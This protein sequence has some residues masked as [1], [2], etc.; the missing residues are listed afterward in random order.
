MKPMWVKSVVVGDSPE[1]AARYFAQE[2]LD[3]AQQLEGLAPVEMTGE[4]WSQFFD[5]CG[6]NPQ[7][8][9]LATRAWA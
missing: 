6:G 2:R 1:E 5:V 8:L 4:E 7:A 3:Q 9:I